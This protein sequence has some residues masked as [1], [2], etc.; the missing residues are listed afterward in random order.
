[1]CHLLY[2][3]TQHGGHYNLHIEHGF[4]AAAIAQCVNEAEAGHTVCGEERSRNA[5]AEKF[6]N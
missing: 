2:K 5:P 1:M 6:G 3:P 4:L